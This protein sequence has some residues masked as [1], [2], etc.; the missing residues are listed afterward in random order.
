FGYYDP[1]EELAMQQKI[2]SQ[3]R[4][5]AYLHEETERRRR[6]YE[7]AVRAEYERRREAEL[8]RR[9]QAELQRRRQA[10]QAR[11]RHSMYDGG[12]E[13]LFDALYGGQLPHQEREWEDKREEKRSSVST[14]DSPTPNP[15][16]SDTPTPDPTSTPY[17]PTPAAAESQ[18]EPE[19]P[20]IDTAPSHAA[21]QSILASFAAL[22]SEFSFPTQPDLLP[23]LSPK[24]AYTPNNAPL[25]GYEHALTGLLT[26]LDAVESYGDSGV[27]KARKEAV[28][29]I[30]ELERLD[31]MKAEAWERITEP[32]P[33]MS[34]PVSVNAG[35]EVDPL[36]VPLPED[37]DVEDEEM[38]G[39]LEQLPTVGQL[40][41]ACACKL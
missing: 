36:S 41:E 34:E 31:G 23:G 16:R 26:Q 28:K 15:A 10:Q 3:R 29:T 33:E 32:K 14:R 21:V 7:A 17:V 25:H 1:Y 30:E 8:E 35:A 22:Q 24:L 13:S 9:R 20:Q 6:E 27:R 18:P 39:T 38:D 11:G 12:L 5:E 19:E 2:Q 4:L 37:S 40:S